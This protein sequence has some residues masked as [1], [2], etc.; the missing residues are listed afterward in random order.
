MLEAVRSKDYS[1]E[2]LLELCQLT[3][4]L[5]SWLHTYEKTYLA[6]YFLLI[7]DTSHVFVFFFLTNKHE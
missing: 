5:I 7:G 1:T 4:Q 6:V 2:T 3:K